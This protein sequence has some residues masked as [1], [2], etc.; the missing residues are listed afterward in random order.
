MHVWPWY[1]LYKRMI[2]V[3]KEGRLQLKH[4]DNLLPFYRFFSFY[5]FTLIICLLHCVF[6]AP[7]EQNI[8]PYYH[9]YLQR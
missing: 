2:V 8:D 7:T 4:V 6:T 9:N 3:P 1:V 5:S